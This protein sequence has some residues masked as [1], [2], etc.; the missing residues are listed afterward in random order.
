MPS[1]LQVINRVRV[2]NHPARPF[3]LVGGLKSILVSGDLFLLFFGGF[4]LV[5]E[6]EA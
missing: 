2:F 5:R 6:W 3:T 1:L 4:F